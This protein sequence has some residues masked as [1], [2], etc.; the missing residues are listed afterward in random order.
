[1]TAK[2]KIESETVRELRG[3][4]I[5]ERSKLLPTSLQKLKNS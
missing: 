4:L 3:F 2:L 1:M 5:T